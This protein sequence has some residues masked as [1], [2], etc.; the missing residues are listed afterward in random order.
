V[1]KSHAAILE[2]DETDEF[3]VASRM[4]SRIA[5]FCTRRPGAAAKATVRYRMR[6]PKCALGLVETLMEPVHREKCTTCNFT[7][8][9][10]AE[11]L[12]IAKNDNTGFFQLFD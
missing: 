3:V 5:P 9:D 8:H 10:P 6:C 11:L 12:R 7:W 2:A 4:E 1:R